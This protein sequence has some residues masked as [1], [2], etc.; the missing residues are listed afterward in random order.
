MMQ[1]NKIKDSDTY[2]EED[3][4]KPEKA[5]YFKVFNKLCLN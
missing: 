2:S 1:N 4:I 5:I 3:M